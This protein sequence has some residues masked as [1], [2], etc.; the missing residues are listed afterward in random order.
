MKKFEKTNRLKNWNFVLLDILSMQLAFFVAQMLRFG[1]N[2]MYDT[3]LYR[4]IAIVMGLINLCMILFFRSYR[5]ILNRG[6]FKEL[7]A[8][9]IHCVLILLFLFAYM[10]FQQ[11]SRNFSRSVILGMWFLSVPFVYAGRL[12]LKKLE[13]RQWREN[14]FQKNLVVITVQSRVQ[15]A[16]TVFFENRPRDYKISGII[17]MDGDGAAERFQGIPVVAHSEKTAWKY[18]QTTIVDEVFLV[19]PLTLPFPEDIFNRCLDMGIS[20]RYSLLQDS[21]TLEGAIHVEGFAGHTVLTASIRDVPLVQFFLKRLIDIVGSIVGILI[22][23]IALPVIAPIVKKQS[24]GPLFFT[25]TRVGKNGRQFK[26]FKFRSMYRDAEDR[27]KELMN[28]NEMKGHMF[29]LKSD[30][31]IF[32]F[33]SIMRRYS[34]DELPQFINVLRGEMSLV[35]TRPPTVDEYIKYDY[36]HKKRLAAK[37]GITGLWQISGRNDIADFEEVVKLD[38]QYIMTWS[39]ALDLKILLKTFGAVIKNKGAA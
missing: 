36:T 22:M 17:L 15:P 10:F 11:I 23:A 24:P 21:T 13:K 37:P 18:L 12:L 25:Q 4:Q 7:Q 16:L 26:I 32:P 1:W 31:R 8:T 38:I 30:P 5:N 27:K 28:Q 33:G 14:I 29:K 39:F 20:V 6:Y 34:I 19:L 2:S 35:G 9:I 3:L